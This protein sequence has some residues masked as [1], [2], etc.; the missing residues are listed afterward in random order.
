MVL[1]DDR[2]ERERRRM[3]YLR[4]KFTYL[5]SKNI[6]EIKERCGIS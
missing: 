4:Q 6:N 1:G 2:K 5:L 3:A